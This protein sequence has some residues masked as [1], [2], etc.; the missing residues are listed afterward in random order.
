MARDARG[1]E[2]LK[3]AANTPDNSLLTG[4]RGVCEDLDRVRLIHNLSN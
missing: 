3:A 1:G 4:G 2:P